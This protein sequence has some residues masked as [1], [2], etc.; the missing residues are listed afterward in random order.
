MFSCSAMGTT[1]RQIVI[2]CLSVALFE[3]I[4]SG[5]AATWIY[6]EHKCMSISIAIFHLQNP[7]FTQRFPRNIT[8]NTNSSLLIFI[9][10]EKDSRIKTGITVCNIIKIIRKMHF[11]FLNIIKTNFT[12]KFPAHV[13]FNNANM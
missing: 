3:T 2:T 7:F 6:I 9:L 5:R 8:S 1:Y 10:N 11:F 13:P 4:W 12:I